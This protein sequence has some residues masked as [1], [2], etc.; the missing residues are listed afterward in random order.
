MKDR[1]LLA[2]NIINIIDVKNNQYFSEFMNDDVYDKVYEYM[3]RL[4]KGNDAATSC[5]KNVMLNNKPLFDRIINDE[6][7]PISEFN[8][9]MELFRDY[10][11]K[12]LM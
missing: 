4:S 7:I 2:R 5:A 1:E 8:A 6:D 11:R 12:Y 3:M 10:K 9:M